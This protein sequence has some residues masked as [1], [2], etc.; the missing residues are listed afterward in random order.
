[1]AAASCKRGVHGESRVE[2]I[3]QNKLLITLSPSLL[4]LQTS[5]VLPQYPEDADISIL[6]SCPTFRPE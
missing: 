1:M 5:P 2:I 4:V 6:E 3:F